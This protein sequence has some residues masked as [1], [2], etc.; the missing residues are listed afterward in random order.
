MEE[1]ESVLESMVGDGGCALEKELA[2]EE[3]VSVK[4]CYV[5]MSVNLLGR[6][7]GGGAFAQ[8]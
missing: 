8:Q 4:G 3:G 6:F 7:E 5:E 1:T 2:E